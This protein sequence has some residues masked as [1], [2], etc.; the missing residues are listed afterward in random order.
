M[1]YIAMMIWKRCVFWMI[2]F[3]LLWWF[4]SVN[5]FLCQHILLG[6]I[7]EDSMVDKISSC[8][9]CYCII[10]LSD[11]A[12]LPYS[13][14]AVPYSLTILDTNDACFLNAESRDTWTSWWGI[15]KDSSLPPFIAF[16]FFSPG[17]MFNLIKFSVQL[18]NVCFNQPCKKN[19]MLHA[20]NSVYNHICWSCTSDRVDFHCFLL[21]GCLFWW[22]ISRGRNMFSATGRWPRWVICDLIIYFGMLVFFFA[23]GLIMHVCI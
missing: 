7:W 11:S 21:S 14:F 22:W 12:A 2:L 17:F 20:E 23:L 3:L 5:M 10:Y 9:S 16:L 8:Y 13:R 1:G 19:G 4:A 18:L 6:L 15:F